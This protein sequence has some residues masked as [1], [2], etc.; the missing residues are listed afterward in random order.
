MKKT[1]FEK[2]QE[3]L[4]AFPTSFP[5]MEDGTEL[6]ILMKL[7]SATEAELAGT[8]PLYGK[9]PP[10]GA[11]MVAAQVHRSPHEV[12][13]ELASMAKKGLIYAI[14]DK[15][16]EKYA[17]LPFMPGILEFNVDRV[18]PELARLAD[19]FFFKGMGPEMA[20]SKVNMMKFVPVDQDAATKT[21]VQPHAEVVD[22]VKRSSSICVMPCICRTKKKALEKDCG[23]PVNVCLYLNEF[24]DFLNSV[25][26]GRKLETDE[27]LALLR[28]ARDAGLV[29]QVTNAQ[30]P[31]VICSCCGC[32]C[33]GLRGT[34]KMINAGLPGVMESDY[35]LVIDQ[36]ACTGCET[37]L[38]RCWTRALH[39][40]GEHV[41]VEPERC[42]G[43]GQ[44]AY[45]CP[46]EALHLE[47]KP[48]QE[49]QH[50]HSD[51]TDVIKQMGWRK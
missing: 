21:T 40:E 20:K 2:L 18:D 12:E 1:V 30:K 23:R 49:I 36:K 43:C 6:R 41:V 17:L 10:I 47:Q 32:C 15:G 4:D 27:A 25:G 29:H 5:R 19:K 45:V 37:C 44:C 16:S 14:G 28:E 26:K 3:R 42:I 24:A 13:V 11:G 46:S 33:L 31:V 22:A 8:L 48:R 9:E 35:R 51:F 38:N 7:F 34:I 39:M 50:R